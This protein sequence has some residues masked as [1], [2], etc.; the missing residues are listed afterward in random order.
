MVWCSLKT[1]NKGKLECQA[2]IKKLL[3]HTFFRALIIVDK[4]PFIL[5]EVTKGKNALRWRYAMDEEIHALKK[6]DTWTLMEL[7]K[8]R[9]TIG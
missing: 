5:I 6:N 8:E 2:S 3:I 7:Q 1:P 9:K 4:K